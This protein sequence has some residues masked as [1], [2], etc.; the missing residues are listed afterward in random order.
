M[1]LCHTQ[2]NDSPYLVTVRTPGRF[3]REIVIDAGQPVQPD[4]DQLRILGEV[5]YPNA[6][7]SWPGMFPHLC[8]DGRHGQAA[9]RCNSQIQD[10]GHLHATKRIPALDQSNPDWEASEI[11]WDYTDNFWDG[12]D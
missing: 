5:P 10:Q 2:A 1:W 11:L 9:D 3:G 7:W 4:S 6:C 8:N 12:S